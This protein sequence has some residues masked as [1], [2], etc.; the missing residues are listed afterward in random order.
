MQLGLQFICI[1]SIKLVD[2]LLPVAEAFEGAKQEIVVDHIG[3]QP[4]L[5][6]DILGNRHSCLVAWHGSAFRPWKDRLS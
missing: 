5:L 2:G 1:H 3:L 4:E 6:M